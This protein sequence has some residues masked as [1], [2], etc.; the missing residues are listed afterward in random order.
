MLIMGLSALVALC[1]TCYAYAY[2][3]VYT[4]AYD[5]LITVLFYSVVYIIVRVSL[6]YMLHI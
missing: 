1:A 2:I 5:P 4:K 3:S 6:G